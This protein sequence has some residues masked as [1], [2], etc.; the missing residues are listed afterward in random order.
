M[1]KREVISRHHL[2]MNKLRKRPATYEQI[3]NYLEEESI[4]QEYDFNISKRTFQR[5]I[6]DILSLYGL[7]ISYNSTKGVYEVDYDQQTEAKERVMEA[8]DT[9]NALNMSDRIAQYI[10]FEKRKPQGTENLHG[11]LHAIKNH[12]KIKFS[13]NKF[14]DEEI[15]SRHVEPY[16]LKEFKNR[17]Y[18]LAK[19][20]KD[21]VIKTFALDRLND[22]EILKTKF[23]FPADFD[24]NEYFKYSFGI[25]CPHD[26]KPEE[27]ILSFTPFQGKYVKTLPLHESQKVIIDNEEEF[28]IQLNLFITH[29]LKME[30]LTFGENL[31]VI[32]P[33]SL[34][35]ELKSTF[36]KVLKLYE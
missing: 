23:E 8:F 16:A 14:Y 24:V 26:E 17:W 4:L 34:I 20:L 15:S 28:R 5:D 32:Q 35:D 36:T 9:F 30:L 27:I 11:F 22:L 33:Q 7:E 25:I 6:K 2:I 29:D 13:Y 21:N 31:K 3:A 1:S 19:D 10:H 18:V 12:F